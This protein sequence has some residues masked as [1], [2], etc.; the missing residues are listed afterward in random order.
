MEI[1]EIVFGN[2]NVEKGVTGTVNAIL[3][4][5]ASFFIKKSKSSNVIQNVTF[6]ENLEA[7]IKKDEV[8]G[9]V[10][11]TLDDEIIKQIDIV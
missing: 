1:K 8:L 5:D 6:R 2:L 3:S 7:P 9:T 11:Y 4:E 10:T